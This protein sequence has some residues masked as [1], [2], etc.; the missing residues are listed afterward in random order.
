MDGAA[1]AP[2][3]PVSRVSPIPRVSRAS[4][5]ARVGLGLGAVTAGAAAARGLATASG[6]A[7][8]AGRDRVV[9][10]FALELEQLQAA[11]YSQALGSGKLSGEAHQF[12]QLVGSEE[13]AHLRYL[14]RALGSEPSPPRYDFGGAFSDQESFLATAVM[15]ED[16]G[17]ASYNGQA[18]NVSPRLLGQVA[19]VILVEARH[20]AWAR[21]LAGR[22]PAP[23][24]ADVPIGA[25]QARAALRRFVA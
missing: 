10:E 3:A 21:S 1:S 14:H 15:L 20:S 7:G 23:V 18:E 25:T 11:F 9:L 13:Q 22:Q 2:G 19:R 4:L 24:A 5:L 17:L 16:T 12:A 6:A 8:G